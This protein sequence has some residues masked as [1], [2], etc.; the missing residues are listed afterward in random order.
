M[1]DEG[2]SAGLVVNVD[3]LWGST[4]RWYRLG[5]V[6]LGD[7]G[8]PQPVVLYALA[9]VLSAWAV[10][11]VPVVG[12]GWW[13]GGVLIAIAFGAA[14]LVRPSGLPVH[15][16]LPAAIGHLTG[17]RHLDGWRPCPDPGAGW[18]PGPVVLEQDAVC[19]RVDGV[20]FEGPGL[21]VWH[22]PG[23]RYRLPR[24]LGDRVRRRPA[25]QILVPE[26][27][28]GWLQAGR[29][30]EVPVGHRLVVAGGGR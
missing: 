5:D 22:R 16:F 29:E 11:G 21:V 23:E 28:A 12:V 20:V 19:T 27:D 3:A 26:Q 18:R 15:V 14:G 10:S 8:I 6:S 25:A 13:P 4:S 2:E 30:V 7:R 24:T 1:G 17:C 9:G